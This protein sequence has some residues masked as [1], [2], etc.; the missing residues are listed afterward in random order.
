[1]SNK[2]LSNI[3]TVAT[4]TCCLDMSWNW[5]HKTM[6][7]RKKIEMQISEQIDH[8]V[9]LSILT[10]H[11]FPKNYE[12]LLDNIFFDFKHLP[13]VH[14]T[15]K[16]IIGMIFERETV[17]RWLKQF[18]SHVQSI[19]LRAS[20]TSL[21]RVLSETRKKI[22]KRFC[23]TSNILNLNWSQNGRLQ[24]FIARQVTSKFV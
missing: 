15:N 6:F 12:Y 24:F 2:T 10:S 17:I 20:Q 11:F 21:T 7:L 9:I 19:G 3:P 16:L 5:Y 18:L 13:Y 14:E 22:K 4:K 1:M 23:A 8:T